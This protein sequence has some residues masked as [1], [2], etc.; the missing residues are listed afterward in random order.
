MKSKVLVWMVLFLLGGCGENGDSGKG[1]GDAGS[2]VDSGS[3][4]EDSSA[5]SEAGGESLEEKEPNLIQ[6][7]NPCNS[8]LDD[9]GEG[10]K[11]TVVFYVQGEQINR[12]LMCT[13][14]GDIQEAQTCQQELP[15]SDGGMTDNCAKGLLCLQLG[16]GGENVCFKGCNNQADCTYSESQRCLSLPGLPVSVCGVPQNQI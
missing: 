9:C 7:T 3:Q 15:T 13:E 4:F 5:P 6:V 1:K 14:A 8:L 10:F 2:N 12:R 16:E 11:C